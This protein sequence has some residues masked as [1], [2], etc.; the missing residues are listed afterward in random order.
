[1]IHR[2][3]GKKAGILLCVLLCCALLLVGCKDRPTREADKLFESLDVTAPDGTVVKQARAALDALDEKQRENLEHLDQFL[4]AEKEYHANEVDRLIE[5]IG[6]VSLTSGSAIEAARNAYEALDQDIA[7]RVKQLAALEKAEQDFHTVTVQ[8]AAEEIDQ[9]IDAIG[10]VTLESGEAIEA[11]KQAYETADPEV[12][13]LVSKL[14][15]LQKA[16]EELHYL[17]VLRDAKAMDEKI[18]ALGEITL[19]SGPDIESV[20]AEYEALNTEIK[21]EVRELKTLE[22][23]EAR[24]V[25]LGKLAQ[26]ETVDAAIAALGEITPEK[27]ADVQK[28][29]KEYESLPKDVQ[30]LVKKRSVLEEAEMTVLGFRDESVSEEIKKLLDE[31]QYTQAIETAEKQIAGR[32]PEKVNGKLVEY[33]ITAY[34]EEANARIKD[35][36]YEEADKLLNQCVARYA[37]EDEKDWKAARKKLDK[38]IAEPKNGQV[39][40]S[41]ARGGY[42]TLTIKSGNKPVFVKVISNK[43]EKNTVTFYVQK[44]SSAKVKIK[45]GEYS[46]KYATGDKWYGEKELFGSDTRYYNAD[47][48][49]NMTTNR[50]GNRI[51]YQT[52]TIT[53]FT[54]LGGNMNT[55]KI[56]ADQF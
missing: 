44:D 36:Q 49:M 29:R 8:H 37:T 53:L 19:E 26:A 33:C 51:E 42:C 46:L 39:F 54:V 21:E 6:P 28:V 18:L 2:L 25:Y 23:A 24:L 41:K 10:I 15:A 38:A 9:M 32:A 48:T 52:Y 45:N 13:G 5:A 22:D 14:P 20:R 27:E 4:E 17:E 47:I 56:P 50:K 1:M 7:G 11:A 35:K 43:D 34:V 55:E 12:A 40:S 3:F 30:E 16:E 31:K